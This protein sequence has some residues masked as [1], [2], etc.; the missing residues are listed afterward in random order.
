M[1]RV[2]RNALIAALVMA[3]IAASLTLWLAQVSKSPPNPDPNASLQAREEALTLEDLRTIPQDLAPLAKAFTALLSNEQKQ[4]LRH[5]FQEQY[6]APWSKTELR[7]SAELV[8][9]RHQQLAAGTWYGEN[10]QRVEP[11]RLAQLVALTDWEHF[12]SMHRPGVVV[13]PALLR[14][15]PTIRP[16]YES[17][18][19]FP[20]DHLQFAE[21]K[22][23]EPVSILH[24]SSDGAWLYIETST[25]SGWVEPE[26][27]AF[28]ESN[29]QR[30]LIHV[31]HLVIVRDFATVRSD[32]GKVLAQA[33]IGTLYPLVAEEAD[34][35]LVEAAKADADQQ[36]TF[37]WARIAKAD[38]RHHPLPFTPENLAVIGNELLKTPYGW[39]EV[40]RNRDCS[41]T[42]RDF[43]LAFGIHLPR[44]SHQ[45]I[46]AGPFLP[47][48]GLS[49][50]DKERTIREQGIPFRTLL[51]LTG[52]IMLYV[53]P[54]DDKLLVLHTLWGLRYIPTN[55]AEKKYII[56]RTVVS[57]LQLGKELPLTKGTLLD[58]LEGMLV[59]PMDGDVGGGQMPTSVKEAPVEPQ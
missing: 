26:A 27:V 39:G 28:V 31:D 25:V 7:F 18:D 49:V 5:Q 44:N 33:K 21:I 4:R 56:G 17:P 23:Q 16:L 47:L 37:T 9:K 42:T 13:K 50:G 19:D 2:Q 53:G 55:A 22:P 34:H 40:F 51:Y 43:F 52:H 48:T 36:A 59:L 1:S 32:R 46:N 57:S 8:T 12:P 58:R 6:F 54:A 11:Q 3:I 10:R 14:I 30:R 20:F 24:A 35:W 45:Q 15:L 38:G 41:A 29:A